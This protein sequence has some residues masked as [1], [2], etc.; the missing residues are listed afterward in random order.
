MKNNM[1][2]FSGHLFQFPTDS[3]SVLV[4]TPLVVLSEAVTSCS[5]HTVASSQFYRQM[6]RFGKHQDENIE[7]CERPNSCLA[8]VSSQLNVKF[9]H[10]VSKS[11]DWAYYLSWSV[12]VGFLTPIFQAF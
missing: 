7:E 2:T 11:V 12:V 3:W 6:H 1:F 10:S 5:A 9:T 4:L 8:L